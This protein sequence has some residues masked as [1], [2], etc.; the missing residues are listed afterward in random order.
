MKKRLKPIFI[1]FISIFLIIIGIISWIGIKNS[2]FSK[3]NFVFMDIRGS[4]TQVITEGTR[5]EKVIAL[6]FDDGPH[7]EFTP[8]ILDLLKEYEAKATFFILGKQAKLYPDLVKREV[9]EGHELGNHT[10]SHIDVKKASKEKIR[11]EFQKTQDT[12]YLITGIKPKVFRPPYGFYNEKTIDVANE[13]G[14]KII[15]W[16]RNQDSKDWSSPGVDKIVNT[17][18]TKTENGDIILL[19]DYI[20]GNSHTVDALK[21]ILPHLKNKGYRFVTVSELLDLSSTY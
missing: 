19:H 7:P 8:Q 17:V 9:E 12:I 2:R 10:F 1:V 15:L 4:Y 16:S 6:T 5:E 20:E 3:H 13:N 18:I 21:V 11:E 14:C